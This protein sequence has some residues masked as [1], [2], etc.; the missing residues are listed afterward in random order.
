MPKLIE[1]LELSG[2]VMT[3]DS[4]HT[5]SVNSTKLIFSTVQCD[6]TCD[7]TSGARQNTATTI[8]QD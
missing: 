4:A 6:L 1:L 7:G 2:A 8:N 3:V 5:K